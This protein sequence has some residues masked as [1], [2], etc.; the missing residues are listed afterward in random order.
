MGHL[1]IVCTDQKRILAVFHPTAITGILKAEE[2]IVKNWYY[3]QPQELESFLKLYPEKEEDVLKAFAYWI[4]T[5][6]KRFYEQRNR[7]GVIKCELKNFSKTLFTKLRGLASR[8]AK[9]VKRILK[10]ERQIYDEQREKKLN[11]R[12]P[13]L[14]A[15][16]L[17]PKQKK[18][19]KLYKKMVAEYHTTQS[20]RYA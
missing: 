3:N 13:G 17:T 14:G 8:I 1:R 20:I 9:Q 5:K 15:A 16:K 6:A 4:L 12:K 10:P 2:C 18:T 7:Y 11:N 19:I